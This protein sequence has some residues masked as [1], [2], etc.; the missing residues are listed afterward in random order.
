MKKPVKKGHNIEIKNIIIHRIN[1][2]AGRKKTTV[3]LAEKV[4][5]TSDSEK[6]FIADIR[7]SHDKKSAPTYGIF[8][9]Q[10]DFNVF[11]SLLGSYVEGK[12]NFIEFTKESAKY[13]KVVIDTSAPATGGFMIFADYLLTDKGFRYILRSTAFKLCYIIFNFKKLYYFY[14]C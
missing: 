4:L 14:I 3:K 7:S 11:Q 9:S 5:T 12:L 6:R 10:N 13:Y 1:K 8:E 2:E